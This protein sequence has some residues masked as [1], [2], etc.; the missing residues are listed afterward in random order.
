MTTAIVNCAKWLQPAIGCLIGRCLLH[1]HRCTACGRG[2]RLRQGVS[3]PAAPATGA[4]ARRPQTAALRCRA[5]ARALATV[6]AACMG[7]AGCRSRLLHVLFYSLSHAL[8]TWQQLVIVRDTEE[9]RQVV[10]H[11]AALRVNQ[12]VPGGRGGQRWAVVSLRTPQE[13]AASGR[14]AAAAGGGKAA[15]LPPQ[16]ARALPPDSCAAA[17]SPS[18]ACCEG[19]AAAGLR[20]RPRRRRAKHRAAPSSVEQH[21]AASSGAPC[22]GCRLPCPAPLPSAPHGRP[23]PTTCSPPLQTGRC[24]APAC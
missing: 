7:R 8:L 19:L 10:A 14:C 16:G 20:Q 15:L 5:R 17:V 23:P 6:S 18:V 12:Y 3:S 22:R 21:R 24:A 2:V 13:Q 11:I 4:T 9:Q 1:G